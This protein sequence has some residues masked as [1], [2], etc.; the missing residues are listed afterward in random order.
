M[1]KQFPNCLITAKLNAGLIDLH[2]LKS[3][4]VN[5]KFKLVSLIQGVLTTKV[6]TAPQAHWQ[7]FERNQWTPFSIHINTIIEDSH[8]KKRDFVS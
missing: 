3:E 8:I 2:G 6:L 1:S 5:A 4:V 7:Y